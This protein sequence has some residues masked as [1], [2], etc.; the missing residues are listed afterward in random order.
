M[1]LS[2][3]LLRTFVAVAETQNFTRAGNI[4]SRTQSAVSMQ[5]KRLESEVGRGLLL[6]NG[7]A[8][9]VSL[10]REGEELLRYSRRILALHDE[11]VAAVSR[12]GVEGRVRLGMPEDF[13]SCFL[14]EVLARFNQAHPNAVVDVVCAT[15]AQVSEMLENGELDMAVR[16]GVAP[17]SKSETLRR[18]PLVWIAG[19]S[20]L[21]HERDPV[22]LAVYHETCS[23]GQKSIQALENAGKSY[24][25]AFTSL[26]TS[27]VYA[28][29]RAGLAVG[30]VG[31]STLPGYENDVLTLGAQDGFPA[32]AHAT[33]TLHRRKGNASEVVERL[34][35]HVREAFQELN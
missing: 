16:S 2:N 33:V 20:G 24:R 32:P 17:S 7:G 14:P 10:T 1:Q 15:G 35:E 29:V 19:R 9:G 3:D 12:P 30:V 11:A 22:P 23:Y 34:A 31:V 13:A 21:V 8:G 25:I 28:A 4:V 27:G 18:E 26:S 5:M 6:R